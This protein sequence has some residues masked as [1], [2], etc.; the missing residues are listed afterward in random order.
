MAVIQAI[1]AFDYKPDGSQIYIDCQLTFLHLITFM[2][3]IV[4]S[5]AP[6]YFFPATAGQAII[7][8]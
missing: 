5:L 7:R 4:F 6:N 8:Y 2:R 1:R 3:L